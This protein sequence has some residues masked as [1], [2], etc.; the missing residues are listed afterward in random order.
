MS[1]SANDSDEAISDIQKE[2]ESPAASFWD[3]AYKKLLEQDDT[4][5]ILED[6]D[7][8]IDRVKEQEMKNENKVSGNLD[9]ASEQTY[10]AVKPE[11][12]EITLVGKENEMKAFVSERMKEMVSKE[13]IVR[14]KGKEVFNVRRG[15]TQVVKIVQKFSGLASQA[16]S[17]DPLH[18]GLAWAG[19][20]CV[21][22]VCTVRILHITTNTDVSSSSSPILKSAKTR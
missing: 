7:I 18:A 15:V 2:A 1:E 17:L 20:C 8:I 3:L 6:Y 14:W 4:R 9:A 21:L 12:R 13:W 16:A 10:D 22:P 19:V 5:S 11:G